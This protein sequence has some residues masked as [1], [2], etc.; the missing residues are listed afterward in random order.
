[1][2]VKSFLTKSPQQTLSLG[3]LLAQKY[4][5]WKIIA[6]IGEIGAGKTS[7]VKGMISYL[8]SCDPNEVT[9]PT[10][11]YLHIYQGNFPIHHFDLYRLKSAEE[12][13]KA[14][15]LEYFHSPGICLI[16]WP[17]KITR[18]LPKNTLTILIEYTTFQSRTISIKL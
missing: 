6:L 9:S 10:F 17:E 14:G 15:F 7:L 5:K 18:Y 1:M 3:R 13:E 16:E 11:N 2:T 12:F 8:A 4:E